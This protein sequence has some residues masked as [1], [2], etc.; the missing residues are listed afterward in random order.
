MGAQQERCS[1]WR[2]CLTGS[3]ALGPPLVL[4]GCRFERVHGRSGHLKASL[5][6]FTCK[7]SLFEF[8]CDVAC[9]DQCQRLQFVGGFG[10]GPVQSLNMYRLLKEGG[11]KTQGQD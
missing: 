9:D 5:F 11:F 2:W 8:T 3:V 6:E 4:R 1:S 10:F 7:S